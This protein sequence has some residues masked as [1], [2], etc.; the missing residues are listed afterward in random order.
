MFILDRP[1]LF[2]KIKVVGPNRTKITLNR[3]P[4]E[5]HGWTVYAHLNG[6]GYKV[7]SERV[8]LLVYGMEPPADG[9][10]EGPEGDVDSDDSSSKK[11]ADA[12]DSGETEPEEKSFT[13]S[14][15]EKALRKI[16]AA[17][18]PRKPTRSA[19]SSSPA[20]LPSK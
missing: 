6:N 18:L 14:C 4:E 2:K 11:K 3:V 10:I 1:K 7:N 15:N 8:Q 13:I 9:P 19:G 20:S 5:M 17:A 12:E 16:D